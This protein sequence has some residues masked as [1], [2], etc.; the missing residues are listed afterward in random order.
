MVRQ[1]NPVSQRFCLFSGATWGQIYNGEI[2]K[3][4]ALMVLY[5]PCVWC[6]TTSTFSGLLAYTVGDLADQQSAAGGSPLLVG[7]VCL[8]VGGVLS[9][10]AMVNAYR[11]AGV[12]NKRQ[13]EA[14]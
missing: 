12:I 11:K 6:G 4:V 9:Q 7:L 10:F 8:F 13:V 2:R 3:G 1:Q 5:A 14:W